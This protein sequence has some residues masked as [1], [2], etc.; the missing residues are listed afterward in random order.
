MV[1]RSVVPDLLTPGPTPSHPEAAAILGAPLIYHESATFRSEFRQTLEDL[2]WLAKTSLEPVITSS[3][4]TGACGGVF[5]NLIEPDDPVLLVVNGNFSQMWHQL[6][7]ASGARVSVLNVAWGKVASPQEIATC[8]DRLPDVRLV[9]LVHC[10]TSTGAVLDLKAISAICSEREGVLLA[11]DA[12]T[13]IGAVPIEMDTWGIDVLVS[14]SQKAFGVPPGL[15]VTWF[16]ERAAHRAL[17][18][19]NRRWDWNWNLLRERQQDGCLYTPSIPLLRALH[20]S[21]AAMRALGHESCGQRA[22]LWLWRLAR[23]PVLSASR[24][25]PRTTAVAFPSPGLTYLRR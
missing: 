23:A 25:S 2:A 10:E 21:A 24:C 19:A 17:R 3:S 16:S 20:R 4:I 7:A 5:S 1:P 22:T 15:G 14:G 8:L 12:A 11:V 6:A 13:S 9:A 18:V